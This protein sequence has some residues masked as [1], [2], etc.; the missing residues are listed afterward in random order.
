MTLTHILS[1]SE[2]L[3]TT[4]GKYS[5]FG[6]FRFG[7]LINIKLKIYCDSYG[8]ISYFVMEG[9]KKLDYQTILGRQFKLIEGS[10]IKKWNSQRRSRQ[11]IKP[12]SLKI[13]PDTLQ[14]DKKLER[15]RRS[16]DGIVSV[17][18]LVPKQELPP[19]APP[20][21]YQKQ[22]TIEYKETDIS[23]GDTTKIYGRQTRTIVK[24]EEIL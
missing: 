16:I 6:L 2:I 20:K 22:K 4:I 19:P 10:V 13:Q 24:N 18:A 8:T 14:L 3:E 21:P 17:E 7:P 11:I 1:T 23:F 15:T 12:K 9:P 5:F